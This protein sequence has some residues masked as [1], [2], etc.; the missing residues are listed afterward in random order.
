MNISPDTSRLIQNFFR[1]HL[2]S[3]Q[4]VSPNTVASYRDTFRM[5][6]PFAAT[7]GAH[8]HAAGLTIDDLGRQAVLAFL[9]QLESDRHNCPSTRNARLAALR[10]FFRFAAIEEPTAEHVAQQVLSI[11]WKR[12]AIRLPW[13]AHSSLISR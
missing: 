12:T 11:P 13:K 5:F 3:R 9:E 2:I 1:V 8:G 10:A 7:C 4:S 6:L